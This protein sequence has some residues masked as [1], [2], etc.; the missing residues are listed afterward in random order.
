MPYPIHRYR[1]LAN[2]TDLEERALRELG[3]IETQRRRGE[4]FQREGDQLSGF[5][6]HNAGWISS[7]IVLRGGRRLIQKVHLPGDILGTPSMAL[8]TAAHTLTCITDAVTAYVPYTRFRDLYT[9]A[10]RV[11]ALFTMAVQIE[12]LSLID[13]LAAVGHASARA[14]LSR[15]LLDLRARLAPLGLVED[16]AFDLPLTQEV[17]GDLLG[18]TSVHV[19]RTI[20]D[21]EREGLIARSDHRIKLVDV[22]KLQNLSPL[23]LR[24][25]AFEPPW[26]PPRA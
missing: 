10:P 23:P 8:Q 19:N 2:L 17:L 24:Q 13:M 18:L 25:L 7:S 3:P 12:R 1:A 15:L 26:L 21:M 16:D 9:L 6:L 5:H 20:R 11:A 22:A 4:T 14:R